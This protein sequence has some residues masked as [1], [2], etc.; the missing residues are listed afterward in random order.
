[1]TAVEFP[2]PETAGYVKFPN[3]ASRYAM[4]GVFV[5]RL[6]DGSVRVAVTGAGA[7]GVFRVA[8]MEAALAK[9][10]SPGAIAGIAVPAADM[11]ADLHATAD[12]RAHLVGVVARRAVEAA[13]A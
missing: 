4:A 13:L 5:A 11:L 2:I 10:F 7:S 8:E 3:P 6:K 12:Y 1:M 9:D